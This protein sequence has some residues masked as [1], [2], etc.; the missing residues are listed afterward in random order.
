H[1]GVVQFEDLQGPVLLRNN[2]TVGGSGGSMASVSTVGGGVVTLDDGSPGFSASGWTTLNGQGFGGHVA[3]SPSTKAAA[4]WTF[5]GL[6]NGL[7]RVFA[8]WP[9]SPNYSTGAPYRIFDGDTLTASASV[10]QEKAPAGGGPRS[11]GFL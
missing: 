11:G 1:D 4:V 3:V 8:T 6:S 2:A 9:S 10:N 7:Y 5:T